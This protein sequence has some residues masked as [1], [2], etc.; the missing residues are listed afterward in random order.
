MANV[1]ESLGIEGKRIFRTS[2][3]DFVLHGFVIKAFGG[4]FECCCDA[5]REQEKKKKRQSQ[6]FADDDQHVLFGRRDEQHRRRMISEITIEKKVRI[7]SMFPPPP[8]KGP[9]FGWVVG[10]DKLSLVVDHIT[11]IPFSVVLVTVT[12][13]PFSGRR[14]HHIDSFFCGNRDDI[15]FGY[16][17][18]GG[19]A[20][21]VSPSLLRL[22]TF[23]IIGHCLWL[24]ATTL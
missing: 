19:A 22:I 15:T 11:K 2:V 10:C 24:F 5:C 14:S 16:R 9:S 8:P 7:Q 20:R 1:A 3:C 6:F 4:D 12:T 18:T 13:S 23:F 21:F 17:L